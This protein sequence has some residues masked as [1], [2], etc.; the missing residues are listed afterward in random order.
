MTRAVVTGNLAAGH[1][2]VA[3]GEANRSARGCCGG[4][5]P[6]TPQTR[7]SSTS[8][9]RAS[10][11]GASS[12]W[13]SEHSAMAVCIG[14]ALAGARSFTASSSKR[15]ALHGGERLRRRTGT[16][17][18]R[19]GLVPIARSVRRGT[20]GPTTATASPLRD[21]PGCKLYCDSHQDLVTPIHALAFA[22]P[23]TRACCPRDGDAGRLFSAS[24]TRAW[25]SDLRRRTWS[26][27]TLPP[28]EPGTPGADRP[29]R[30]MDR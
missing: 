4:A 10:A 23:R 29:P 22:S 13:K 7:S 1:A 2:L 25:W 16:P 28:L 12:P 18:H 6:I 17:A 15:T 27:L 20:S 5:Y 11:K 3:A 14:T 9:A 24:R 21:R 26:T 30:T 8:W 19:H